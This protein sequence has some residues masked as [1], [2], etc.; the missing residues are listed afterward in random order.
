MSS[1]DLVKTKFE[2]WIFAVIFLYLFQLIKPNFLLV[3]N[4]LTN[5]SLFAIFL[6]FEQLKENIK[7]S[8]FKFRHNQIS[9]W[10]A[11]DIIPV[12]RLGTVFLWNEFKKLTIHLWFLK[13]IFAEGE[14]ENFFVCNYGVGGN[15][16]GEPVYEMDCQDDDKEKSDNNDNKKTVQMLNQMEIKFKERFT[17]ATEKVNAYLH[18]NTYEGFS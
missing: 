13:G 18:M 9:R 1:T 2:C 15:V 7:Q 11:K 6:C 12:F 16:P 17:E 5:K 4:N 8:A 10:H 3:K 14:Y